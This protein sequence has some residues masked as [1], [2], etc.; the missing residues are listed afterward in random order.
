VFV[1][2]L[3]G[4]AENS[5]RVDFL[6]DMLARVLHGPAAEKPKHGLLRRFGEALPLSLRRGLTNAV[7][8]APAN[9]S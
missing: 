4:M 5:A 6:D 1:F 9:R 7:P 3:H 8:S 2:S